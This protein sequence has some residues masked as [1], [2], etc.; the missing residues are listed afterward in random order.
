VTKTARFST[1]GLA[2]ALLAQPGAQAP[3]NPPPASSIFRSG[4]SYVELDAS[5]LDRDRNPVRGLAAGDFTVLEDGQP[6]KILTFSEI[7]VPDPEPAPVAWMRDVT[8]DVQANDAYENR[9]LVVILLDDGQIRM[10]KRQEANTKAVA[11]ALVSRLGPADLAAILFT[12]IQKGSQD[13]TSDHAKLLKAIDA[14]TP[15]LA[16]PTAPSNTFGFDIAGGG[17]MGDYF[18]RNFLVQLDGVATYLAAL[19]GQRKALFYV[20]VGHGTPFPGTFDF[21]QLQQIYRS[22]QQANV[23]IYPIDP[24]G[25]GGVGDVGVAESS[26][27]GTGSNIG[28]DAKQ[29]FLREVADNTGGVAIVNREDFDT[30]VP[31]ILKENGSYYLLGYESP[32]LKTDGKLRK[33]DVKVNRPGM[34]VRAR[35]GYHGAKPETSKAEPSKKNT[36]GSSLSPELEKATGALVE[37]AEIKMQ[38][39]AAP[40]AVPGKR[41]ASVAIT[42]GVRPEALADTTKVDDIDVFAAAFKVDGTMAASTHQPFQMGA[43][44]PQYELLTRLDLKPGRYQL[45]VSAEST[46]RGKA[47]SV[48]TDLDVPDFSQPLSLSGVIVHAD[49]GLPAPPAASVASLVPLTPTTLRDFSTNQQVTALVKIYQGG[50]SKPAPVI[51]SVRIRDIR[52]AVVFDASQTLGPDRFDANRVAEYRVRLPLETLRP[53]PYVLTIEGALQKNAARRDVRFQVR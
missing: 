26:A 7:N 24:S 21:E 36:S 44:W 17:D 16:R 49:P 23:N 13:F 15:G 38:L 9:R 46:L 29:E 6:Q 30:A 2:I 40:F 50:K 3:Q 27:A 48:F 32:N 39:A 19:P 1:F 43:G 41:E 14:F 28:I 4:I 22:S 12:R 20:S 31:R 25:L 53:G 35:S 8:P 18:F 51:L 34:T 52:D 47:G 37:S 10:D 33:I 42:L 5:V 45:R 11:R